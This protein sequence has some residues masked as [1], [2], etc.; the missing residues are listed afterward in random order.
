MP[1]KFAEFKNELLIALAAEALAN[2]DR[3]IPPKEAADRA[4]LTYMAGWVREAVSKLENEGFVEAL[5]Y[6]GD[7]PDGGMDLT[8]TGAGWDEAERLQGARD[9]IEDQAVPAAGR[10]VRLDHNSQEAQQAKEAVANTLKGVLGNNDYAANDPEDYEQRIA[11][12]ESGLR[13]LEAIRVRLDAIKTLLVGGLK[14]LAEKFGDAA[15]GA[16]AT[17]ALAAL[18]SLLGFP[19]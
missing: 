19:I 13:L 2:S 9:G 10:Y 5:Y 4:G 15:I 6:K 8:V 16:L 17:A 14:Y 7:G 3:Y 11:E 12:L 1:G 18:A